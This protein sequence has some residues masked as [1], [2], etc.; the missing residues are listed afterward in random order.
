MQQFFTHLAGTI[1][2]ISIEDSF[3]GVLPYFLSSLAVL[4]LLV[5]FPDLW[6]AIPKALFPKLFL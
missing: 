6:L 2:G 4:L 5:L 1:S 3:K